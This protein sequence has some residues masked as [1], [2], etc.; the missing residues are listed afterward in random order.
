MFVPSLSNNITWDMMAELLLFVSDSPTAKA[1]TLGVSIN[2][3][4]NIENSQQQMHR[5]EPHP[6]EGRKSSKWKLLVFIFRRSI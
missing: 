6:V 5:F 1:G 2:A 4:I 3:M